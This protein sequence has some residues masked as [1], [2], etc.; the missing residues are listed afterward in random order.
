VVPSCHIC[1]KHQAMSVIPGG[2]IVADDHVVVSHHPLTTP[3]A[4]STTVELG[5]LLV[6]VRRHVADLGDLTAIEASSLGRLAAAAARALQDGE[7]AEQVDA[8]IRANDAGHLQL[9]LVARHREPRRGDAQDVRALAE[10]VRRAL[11]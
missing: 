8:S 6:E 5:H 10:R 7:G 4:C 9:E 2:E 1:A 11:P 3:T